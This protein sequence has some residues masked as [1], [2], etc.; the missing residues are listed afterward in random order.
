MQQSAVVIPD[1][2][3][4]TDVLPDGQSPDKGLHAQPQIFNRFSG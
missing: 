4:L 1:H 2:D 3:I